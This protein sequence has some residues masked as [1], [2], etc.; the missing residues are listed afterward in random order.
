MAAGAQVRTGWR[1]RRGVNRT[2][3]LRDHRK[4]NVGFTARGMVDF[5]F[6]H[7]SA[8][9]IIVAAPGVEIAVETREIAAR[10]L[11]PD[12]VAG[13]KVVA[14]GMQIDLQPVALAR[15]HPD[16]MVEALAVAHA[17]YSI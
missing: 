11:Q 1:P 5:V 17:Q 10:N 16:R 6:G 4:Q 7:D 8:R 15:G 14:G 3:T 12:A 13:R 2:W 9:F